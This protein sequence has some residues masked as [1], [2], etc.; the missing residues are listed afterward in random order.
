MDEKINGLTEITNVTVLFV[1]D[2]QNILNSLERSLLKEPYRRIFA[3]SVSQARNILASEPVHIVVSDMNMPETDGLHFLKEVKEKYPHIVRMI[4]SGISEFRTIIAAINTNE[5]YRYISKPLNEP[6]ELKAILHQAIEYFT[7]R[8]QSRILV[9][10]LRE[11][12]LELKSWK[13]KISEDLALAGSLQKKIFRPNP[14]FSRECEIKCLHR[15]VMDVGGDIFGIEALKNDRICIYI[16]D[17]SGHGVGA[18]LVSFLMKA[19]V[20]EA[21]DGYAEHGPARICNEISARYL[22][23]VS[24][25]FFVTFFIGIFNPKDYSWKCMNCGHPFPILIHADG[26][27][28]SGSLPR[29]GGDI[30]I[31]MGF[32]KKKPYAEE[33]EI[34]F[35]TPPGSSA[36]FYTDGIIEAVNKKTGEMCGEDT[37]FKV[38]GEK[39]SQKNIPNPASEIVTALASDGFA[40]E[41]D[42]MTIITATFSDAE[43]LLLEK[44]IPADLGAV[45]SF[46]DELE[47]ILGKAEW[48]DE[49]AYAARL[50]CAEHL[51]NVVKHG[52]LPASS[53]ISFMMKMTNEGASIVVSNSGCEWCFAEVKREEPLVPAEDGYGLTIIKT[54]CTHFEFYRRENRNYAYFVLSKI[55]SLNPQNDKAS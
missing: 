8:D 21:I 41:E 34:R 49:A 32:F 33:D 35:R 5:I 18:A 2:E 30:P 15:P 40:F 45:S 13:D 1:D 14:F 27:I 12:N 10:R 55:F 54:I 22:D 36:V 28:S 43:T 16:G 53:E 17:V 50:L 25:D 26:D 37:L 23:S 4:F 3:Q 44:N 51:T 9:E 6:G 52:F 48:P 7:L 38:A 24:S 11:N 46:T 42:D 29:L 20:K 19:I 47:K 39:L 31:G